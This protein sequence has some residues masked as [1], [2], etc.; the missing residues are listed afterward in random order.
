M[1]CAPSAVSASRTSSSLNGLIIA[2]IIFMLLFLLASTL[3][4]SKTGWKRGRGRRAGHGMAAM[5]ELLLASLGPITGPRVGRCGNS[6]A[7]S[8]RWD[9]LKRRARTSN[10]LGISCLQ[11]YGR[12]RTA[13]ASDGGH[14]LP[15]T[16]L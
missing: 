16:G 11:K 12:P 10:G 15:V 9:G 7:L 1:P 3:G 4:T 14:A 8:A 5:L 13:L 6:T 2:V